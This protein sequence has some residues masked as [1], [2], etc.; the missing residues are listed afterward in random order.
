MP[1]TAAQGRE[2]AIVR[3]KCVIGRSGETALVFVKRS[4]CKTEVMDRNQ[5][6][7]PYKLEPLFSLL[8]IY[9]LWDLRG[10]CNN[11]QDSRT[12]V[13]LPC[14]ERRNTA[15]LA[16]VSEWEKERERK[17]TRTNE[18]ASSLLTVR[19]YSISQSLQFDRGYISLFATL[20]I[21]G[22]QGRSGS[23]RHRRKHHACH[24]HLI[25]RWNC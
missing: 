5:Q 1:L 4:R 10:V 13:I 16:T 25:W 19:A 20:V 15:F 2:L 3:E 8:H 6:S 22:G 18:R 23:R 17:R 14:G 7:M 12:T 21:T 11:F 9:H 24:R